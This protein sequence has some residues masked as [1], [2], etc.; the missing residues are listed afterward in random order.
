MQYEYDFEL[1]P[2][3]RERMDGRRERLRAVA[4]RLRE[5]AEGEEPLPDVTSFEDVS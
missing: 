3:E 4:A 1:N 2:A 5:A